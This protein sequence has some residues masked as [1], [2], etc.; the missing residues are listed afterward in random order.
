MTRNSDKNA[1]PASFEDGERWEPDPSVVSQL[2]EGETVLVH[3]ETNEIY[4]LNRT[5]T[6]AWELIATGEAYGAMRAELQ[7]EF[8]AA[9]DEI[10]GDL[11]KLLSDL[12]AKKLVR[13][14]G[15]D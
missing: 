5:A 11:A 10:E 7:R 13:S 8:D 4:A 2:V 15:S 12:V 1:L 3:L 6:R 9:G 14:R